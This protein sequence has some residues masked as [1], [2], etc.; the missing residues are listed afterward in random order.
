MA[1]G[2]SA[3]GV[4]RREIDL[5][6][7]LVT[8]G[9]S[10]GA[11]VVRAKKGPVRR[12]VLVT[13]D[14]EYIEYF[15]EPYY[16]SGLD[17]KNPAEAAIGGKLVP[18]LGYGAYGALEFLKE[19]NTLFVVRAYDDGDKYAA[20][21][22]NTS[23]D[24]CTTCPSSAGIEPLGPSEDLE[25]F[26]TKERISTYEKYHQDGEIIGALLFGYVGPG[27]DGNNYAVTVE[28]LNP[29]SDWLYQY[30][31][32]PTI[33]AANTVISPDT[34]ATA[35]IQSIWRDGDT[36]DDP[37]NPTLTGGQDA[38]KTYFKIASGVVKVSVYKKPDDKQWEELYANR[39]DADNYKL[40][41]EPLEVFYGSVK[42]LRD[43]DNN[44]LFIERAINGN[45]KLI[46]VKSDTTTMNLNGCW[47][48]NEGI[49]TTAINR[50]YGD[51]DAGFFVYNTDKLSKLKGGAVSYSTG[52]DGSDS[53]F[54]KFFENR[55]ELPI[56]IIINPSYNQIDKLAVADLCNVRR[57]CMAANQVGNVK[58]LNYLDIIAEEKYGYPYPSFMALYAGY[59]RVYD[60]Y[61]DKYVFLPNSIYGASLYARTDRLTAPW[62]APAGVTRGTMAVLDQNKVYNT[63]Q[64]GKM[65]DKNINCVKYVQ[66]AGFAMFGQKT[67]Q[68]K[69]SALD[70][71]QVRRNLIFMQN[72]IETA[73]NQ[74]VFENNTQGTRLRV[75]S[76]I[77]DFLAGVAAGDG[78]YDYK[79]V[80][81]ETNNTPAVIDAN[82]M[83]VDIYV[84]PVKTVEFI[85]FTTVITR[86]GVNF[87]DVQL[88]YA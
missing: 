70:R 59:S 36:L 76:I 30:D 12:P 85:Q 23:G 75:F 26:D 27:E 31:E 24:Y 11:T 53:D 88:K 4:Y 17:D 25:I 61:N 5:S 15:G 65:Y 40:R 60:T 68:L 63:D 6:D 2:Y 8:Q 45:S 38:V 54:W 51:D 37:D 1:G 84:Q 80:V 9:V 72:N 74:F 35:G 67:A 57:D 62:Y 13:N 86:T 42:P 44:E 69:R 33:S 7:V 47:D 78:L 52:L 21:E 55:E 19:T 18:E 49:S 73:L 41:T 66:G 39:T 16:V 14:K 10:N 58:T 20:V 50:P 56:S 83:N 77:D 82:Q 48:F 3:P 22:V 87:G 43:D 64:I 32:Y 34:S 28:T 79:V 29:E 71:I 46:Y 81:D